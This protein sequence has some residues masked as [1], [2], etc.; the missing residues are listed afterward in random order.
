MGKVLQNKRG[1]SKREDSC[2]RCT[3]RPIG[4]KEGEV[5]AVLCH[6]LSSCHSASWCVL[7]LEN[8]TEHPRGN[9]L[10]SVYLESA[11]FPV[12]DSTLCRN[13]DLATKKL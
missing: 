11:I 4:T 2:Q 5:S 13:N 1:C 7:L 3:A 8:N 12:T 9:L 6:L 10:C